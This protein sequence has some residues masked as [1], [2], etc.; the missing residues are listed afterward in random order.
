MRV[1][2]DGDKCVASGL[3]VLQSPNVFDQG[4]H[5]IVKLR[6]EVVPSDVEGATFQAAQTCPSGA[7][8]IEE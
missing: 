4:I 8:E 3:C 6:S 7:I 1:R 2:V 5:G